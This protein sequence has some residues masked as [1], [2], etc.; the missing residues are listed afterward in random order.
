MLQV[1][2]YELLDTIF[3]IAC[4]A[5]VFLGRAS[6]DQAAIEPAAILDERGKGKIERADLAL[7]LKKQP[8]R[9]L[10]SQPK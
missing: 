8:L 3:T 5:A 4:V 1:K 7:S 10:Y 9:R 2:R 6:R